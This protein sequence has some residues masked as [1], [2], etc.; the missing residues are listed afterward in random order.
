MSQEKH[1]PFIPMPNFIEFVIFSLVYCYFSA[2]SLVP[3][4]YIYATVGH[5]CVVAGGGDMAGRFFPRIFASAS[6]AGPPFGSRS[7]RPK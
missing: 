3:V 6:A 7:I 2:T 4:V 5:V 1:S